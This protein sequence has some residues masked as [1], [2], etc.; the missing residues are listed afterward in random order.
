M[1]GFVPAIKLITKSVKNSPLKLT[2]NLLPY[3]ICGFVLFARASNF[4][5]SLTFDCELMCVVL[6]KK[7]Y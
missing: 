5:V 1:V 2:T 6:S 7:V 3:K 4:S